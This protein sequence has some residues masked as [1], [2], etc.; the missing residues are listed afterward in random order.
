MK[1]S[2]HLTTFICPSSQYQYKHLPFGAA[3]VGDM[4]QHKK[5]ETFSDMPNVFGI[6]DDILVIGYDEDGADRDVAVHKV[7]WHCEEVS[8]KLNKEKCHFRCMST[9]FFGEVISREGIQPDPQK[10]KALMDMPAP[11]NKKEL[12]AFSGIINYLGKF[13]PGT[14][15]VCDPLHKLTSSKVTWTWNMSYQAL[16]NKAN[17]L[18]KAEPDMCIKY[19]D[20][21]KPLYLET[22]ASRVGLGVALLQMCEG[23]ACQKD[24]APDNTTLHPTVFASKSLTSAEHRYINIEREALGI[25]H[26]LKKFHHYCFSREVLIITKDKP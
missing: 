13:S 6:V 2:S 20:D 22:D 18:I 5:D 11:K 17:S 3:P 15:D 16:F 21:T 25:L 9:P 26:G 8:L 12:Q 10:I 4:F 23:T 14:T 19:Y 1:K 24:I 7:L